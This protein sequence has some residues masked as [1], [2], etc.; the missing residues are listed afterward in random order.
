M[1]AFHTR[2]IVIWLLLVATSAAVVA[3]DNDDVDTSSS[4]N[5]VYNVEDPDWIDDNPHA[6]HMFENDN[7]NRAAFAKELVLIANLKKLRKLL[8]KTRKKLK[9]TL[10][11]YNGR[12]KKTHQEFTHTFSLE[13]LCVGG[14]LLF[15]ASLF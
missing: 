12:H 7:G 9:T 2:M 4:N 11:K 15:W 10:S 13:G 14:F 3:Q 1:P 5:D 8:D 6:F